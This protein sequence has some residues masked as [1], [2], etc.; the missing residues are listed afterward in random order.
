MKPVADPGGPGGPPLPQDIKKLC[1]FQA[2]LRENPYFEQ[3][4]G[5]GPPFGVKTPMGPPD[6]FWIRAWKVTAGALA[7]GAVWKNRYRRGNHSR[8]QRTDNKQRSPG[9]CNLLLV[10]TTL[11][12]PKAAVP[13]EAFENLILSQKQKRKKKPRSMFW[14]FYDFYFSFFGYMK[15]GAFRAIK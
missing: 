8:R 5:S 2:I 6:Y 7:W 4:L 9:P 13:F 14:N 12:E 15:V 1:N 11:Q 10:L 3:I